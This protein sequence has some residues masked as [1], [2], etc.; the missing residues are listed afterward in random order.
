MQRFILENIMNEQLY[1]IQ[2]KCVLMIKNDEEYAGILFLTD[3]SHGLEKKEA[4][5]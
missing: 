2:G 3:Y 1:S 4:T 5:I